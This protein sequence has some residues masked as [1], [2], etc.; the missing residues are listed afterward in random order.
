MRTLIRT[1]ATFLV[2]ALMAS[3]ALSACAES[4]TA[5]ITAAEQ[6]AALNTLPVPSPVV[7]LSGGSPV[8]SW[9]ALSGATSYSVNLITT[10]YTI[11]QWQT[12]WNGEWIVQAGNTTGT[13]LLDGAR[14]A[15]AAYT[16]EQPNDYDF[17]A[18]DM[19][20][21]QYELVAHFPTGTSSTR[22]YAPVA[23]A[24]FCYAFI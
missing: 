12:Y 3:G 8:I 23:P 22:V 20:L 7:S 11:N 24:Q 1:H 19:F 14:T 10:V 13:S 5:T 16:C 17:S 21:Y 6:P 15:T 9:S 4:P 18:T 2:A